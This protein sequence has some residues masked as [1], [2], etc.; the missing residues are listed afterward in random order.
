MFEG[1]IGVVGE[2]EFL[3]PLHEPEFDRD[4][5]R[6]D[7]ECDI[8]DSNDQ[9]SQTLTDGWDQPWK[10]RQRMEDGIFDEVEDNSP[11]QDASGPD[12]GRNERNRGFE[13]ISKR[14]GHANKG[15]SYIFISGI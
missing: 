11:A 7:N 5:D 13:S 3:D 1:K 9:I 8:E 2:T 10:V 15:L 12:Y 4:A 6:N 14:K